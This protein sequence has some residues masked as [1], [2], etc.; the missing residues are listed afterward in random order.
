MVLTSEQYVANLVRSG[1]LSAE[2][3]ADFLKSL[4]RERQ[5]RDA[6]ELAR[7]LVR[8]DKLTKFQAASVYQGRTKGWILGDYAVVDKIGSGGMGEVFKARHRTMNRM[9]AVKIL[10]PRATASPASLGRFEREVRAA[11]KLMHPNIVTAL[12]AG[13]QGQLHYLVMEY[14]EGQSL[15]ALLNEHG[16]MP[17]ERAIDCVLQVGRGLEYAH[18]KGV[19]H[20]DIKPGN[21]LIDNSGTVKILDMGLALTVAGTGSQP[22]ERLTGSNQALGTCDYMAPE[23]ADDT[24]EIDQRV[25]IYALGCTLCQLLTGDP[26]YVRNSLI[27]VLLAHREAPVPSLRE[28]RAEVPLALDSVFQKM[29]AK[30]P[31]DRYRSMTEVIA[32]LDNC[33][34]PEG[35]SD[36]GRRVEARADT[37]LESFLQEAQRTDEATRTLAATGGDETLDLQ[38]ERDTSPSGSDVVTRGSTGAQRAI[39]GLGTVALA[40]LLAIVVTVLLRGTDEPQPP[41]AD[42]PLR[43]EEAE[44]KL[45][46]AHLVIYWPEEQRQDAILDIDN[47]AH[48][49]SEYVD[50]EDPDQ[51]KVPLEPGRHRIWIVRPGFKPFER[52]FVMPEG[53]DIAIEPHW[54]QSAP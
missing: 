7:E 27:K 37:Q 47:R 31:D 40:L 11:A 41:I 28:A 21:L 32:E 2:E 42:R 26:P 43:V 46:Q 44:A 35:A 49:I 14:V 39:I 22:A 5:P 17:V 51:V 50:G 3:M 13:Q 20:R 10:A 25:D 33:L 45:S 19:I 9:V 1:L 15:T 12:D 8:A 38:A 4:P 48:E 53:E 29:L 54:E 30:K 16:T 34:E 52:R 24:H 36:E 18:S 23:Q 6:Q